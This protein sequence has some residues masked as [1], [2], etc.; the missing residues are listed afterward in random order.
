MTN[1][2]L[3]PLRGNSVR[4]RLRRCDMLTSAFPKLARLGGSFFTNFRNTSSRLCETSVKL[5]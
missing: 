3:D 5:G 4:R 2:K 1:Q